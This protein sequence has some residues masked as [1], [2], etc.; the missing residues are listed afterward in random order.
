MNVHGSSQI[1]NPLHIQWNPPWNPNWLSASNVLDCFT[2]TLNPFYDPNCLNEQ[3]RIQRLSSEILS[4]VHGVEYILLHAAEPLFV[5]RKQYRQPNQNVT[6]LEDYYI[7]GGTVYQAPD[8]SSVFNSRL[9]SAISNVRSAF[10]EAKSYYRFNTSDGYYFQYKNEPPVEKVDTKKDDKTGDDKRVSVFQKYRMDMLLNELSEKFPPALSLEE[11]NENTQD[12]KMT[13]NKKGTQAPAETVQS[14]KKPKPCCACPETRKARDE[15]I[16][17][18]GPDSCKELIEAHRRCMKHIARSELTHLDISVKQL[19]RYIRGFEGSNSDLE[20]LCLHCRAD[21]FAMEQLLEDYKQVLML[22]KISDS[23][24]E[25]F[26]FVTTYRIELEN[27]IQSL[28][29]AI[30]VASQNADNYERELLFSRYNDDACTEILR[31]RRINEKKRNVSE[32][33]QL[34]SSLTSLLDKMN[35]TVQQSELTLNKLTAS[36]TALRDATYEMHGMSSLIHTSGKL[37]KKYKRRQ[38]SDRF[39]IFLCFGIFLLSAA[40]IVKIRLWK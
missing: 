38:F 30:L 29:E 5:I 31:K 18:K 28:R 21:I 34:Q 37:L 24:A 1:T 40:Y 32:A 20:R 9:Q 14:D 15:C 11:S 16:V 26:R 19:I 36:S 13:S 39:I 22:N 25:E 7:I 17:E 4:R 33:R 12:G 3:V 27:N 6:P 10:E 23:D 8:L 35:D 2:N